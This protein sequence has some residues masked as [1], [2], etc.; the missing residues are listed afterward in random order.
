MR[1]TETLE[2]HADLASR[3]EDRRVQSA[4][5][6]HLIL[7]VV[8]DRRYAEERARLVI[9]NLTFVAKNCETFF[10]AEEMTDL[11]AHSAN[12]L[13]ASDIAD[14]RL[15]PTRSGFAYFEKPLAIQD[16]RGQELLINAI[17]WQPTTGGAMVH[18]WNDQTRTPDAAAK[19]FVDAMPN[20]VMRAI[21]RWGYIG[22]SEY[23][24]DSQIGD[25]MVEVSEGVVVKY[26][27]VGIE[28]IPT[29]NT[30]RLIHAFWLL[31]QQKIVMSSLER[32]DRKLTKRLMRA[33]LP[34]D[35]TVIR[36]RHVE[37]PEG[38]GDGLVMWKHRWIVRGFWRWQ[39]YKDDAG[40]WARKRIWIDPYVK[41]PAGA[42]LKISKKVNAVVR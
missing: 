2:L 25:P 22:I 19:A 11:V 4:M 21:G 36:L 1:A 28:P 38:E 27:E 37:Y 39:P 23:R 9:G 15:A 18:M 5:R 40:E 7:D 42:P 31:L 6:E 32:G 12:M 20:E 41:G 14:H 29:S 17:L 34:S 35:V 13:D 30:N 3:V 10:V 33:G 24:D 16:L 8:G 26:A